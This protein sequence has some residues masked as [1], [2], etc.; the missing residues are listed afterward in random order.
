MLHKD[1]CQA[2]NNQI[3]QE[4]SAAYSYL[5]MAAHFDTKNLDGF[6]NWM[7]A[8]HLEEH[9]H[10]M[11]LYRY[12]LDRGGEV[13]LES[14]DRPNGKFDSVRAVFGAALQQEKTNTESIHELYK[15]AQSL[16]D[17]ATQSHL[18][19]FLDEQV[20]EEKIFDEA[21]ALLDMAG[22]DASALLMLNEKLGQR[23][24]ATNTNEPGATA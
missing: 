22:D 9:D 10:A 21:I 2:L 8:Q 3:N 12:L 6:A 13:A 1:I 5:A 4:M 11:R 23:G 14:I 16:N 18:Q 24:T 20:E 15:L 17:F 19:W 7:M